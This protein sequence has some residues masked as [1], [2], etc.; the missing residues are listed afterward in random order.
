[1]VAGSNSIN[2]NPGALV[3]LQNLNS[4]N[5]NLDI[6]QNRVATGLRVNNA[7]EDA[8]NFAIA[9]GLR[10]DLKA[11][12]AVSQGIANARGV[13]SVA[14]SATTAISD[15]AGDIQAKI[16]EGLNAGN[17]SEQ[18][19]IL[20]ADFANLVSQVNT[21][22]SNAQFNGQN[23]LS[24][25][26]VNIASIANIDGTTIN[27]RNGS[28]V[29]AQAVTLGVQ[30]ISSTVAALQAL[31]FIGTFQQ[32]VN[33]VLGTLGA[34]TRSINFQDEFIDSVRDATEVGLGSIVDADLARE[35]ARLQALQVQQQLST[36]SLNIANQRPSVLL[37]LFR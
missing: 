14:L 2:T 19:A 28:T 18:Q 30:S 35:S 26:S 23:L 9:Q 4:I 1:M 10:S 17:T 15:L 25:A 7:V 8:S 6:T 20:Q 36:Q 31:S 29:Q 13:T 11:F 24:A 5:S 32:S 27:V 37:S 3:A 33:T 21:F 34:D 16:T 12:D 22:I